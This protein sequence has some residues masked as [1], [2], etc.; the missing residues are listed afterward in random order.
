MNWFEENS[1]ASK[2]HLDLT[3]FLNDILQ[4]KH[5]A[6]LNNYS[7]SLFNT[8]NMEGLI[9]LNFCGFHPMK[10]LQEKNAIIQN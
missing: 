7:N 6:L 4:P 2:N 8:V 3:R 9:G 1:T 5:Q 10:F